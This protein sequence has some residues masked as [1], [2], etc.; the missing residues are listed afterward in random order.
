[1]LCP[2]V[3]DGISK[4]SRNSPELS[5]AAQQGTGNRHPGLGVEGTDHL[6]GGLVQLLSARILRTTAGNCRGE[7]G[8]RLSMGLWESCVGVGLGQRLGWRLG[9]PRPCPQE[10]KHL[11]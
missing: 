5:K 1:M 8:L 11:G 7:G 2:A 3:S 4:L 10:S 6:D 9:R